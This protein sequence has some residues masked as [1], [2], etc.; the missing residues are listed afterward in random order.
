M[1]EFYSNMNYRQWSYYYEQ[2]IALLGN[3]VFLTFIERNKT[4]VAN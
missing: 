2:M 4:L 3:L 1:V